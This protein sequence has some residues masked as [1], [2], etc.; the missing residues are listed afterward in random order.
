MK[1]QALGCLLAKINHFD[2]VT[3][4]SLVRT[5]YHQRNIFEKVIKVIRDGILMIDQ[6]GQ[7]LLANNVTEELLNVRN[8]RNM[9]LWKCAPEILGQI[10]LGQI[11]KKIDCGGNLFDLSNGEDI[12]ILFGAVY[13]GDGITN[14]LYIFRHYTGPGAEKKGTRRGTNELHFIAFGRCCP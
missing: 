13:C 2:R 4:V 7:I 9:I 12:A 14:Y 6:D 1:E 8:L 3:L 11:Q 10:D 5:F